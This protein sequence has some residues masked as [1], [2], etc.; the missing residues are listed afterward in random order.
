MSIFSFITDILTNKKGTLL[1]NIDS[2]PEYNQYMINRWLSMYSPKVAVII[3][4]TVNRL[5]PIFNTKKEGY[6]F[7]VSVLP[8]Q[9]PYRI[10]YIKKQK[11]EK[12]DD[13]RVIEMLSKNLELSKREIRY[14]IDTNNIDLER[15]KTICR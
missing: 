11:S 9:K 12:S 6:K 5:Y 7:L 14:Y 15:Y 8:R 3:N 4:E 13:E 1:D 10:N 2:E